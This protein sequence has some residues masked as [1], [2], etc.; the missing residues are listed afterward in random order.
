MQMQ[1]LPMPVGIDARFIAQQPTCLVMKERLS[2]SGDDFT[3]RTTNGYDIVR[4]EGKAMSL[5]GRK[6]FYSPDNEL[7]FALRKHHFKFLSS[8]YLEDSQK[9]RFLE[10]KGRMTFMKAKLDAEFKNVLGGGQDM[11][12]EIRGD[13]INREADI[14]WNGQPV[15]LIRR[16]FLNFR[17]IFQGHQTYGVE[18]APN[19]DMALIAALVVSLDESQSDQNSG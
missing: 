3:V 13:W 1:P 18:V 7:L 8:W 19:V 5:S 16:S 9:N 6:N 15:A 14:L 2:F 4:C 12:L 11:I 17:E 10:I